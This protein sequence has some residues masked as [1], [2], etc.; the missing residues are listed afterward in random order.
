M[1]NEEFAAIVAA[2][3]A[4]AKLFMQQCFA[5]CENAVALAAARRTSGPALQTPWKP[6]YDLIERGPEIAGEAPF[7]PIDLLYPTAPTPGSVPNG[8]P[9]SPTE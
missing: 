2:R 8:D 6:E 5:R 7:P 1:T 9:K 3:V 4:A